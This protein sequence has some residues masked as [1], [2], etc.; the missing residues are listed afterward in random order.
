MKQELIFIKLGGSLIT[1][2][3]KRETPRPRIITSI[4]QEIRSFLDSSKDVAL[5][6]GHGSGSY[7]HWEA[8]NYN[9]LTGI[10]TSHQWRGFARVSAAASR[11]NRLV[12]DTFLKVGVPVLSMQPSASIDS[13]A[14]IILEYNTQ[15]IRN[16][17]THELIPLIFGDVAFDR[18]RGGTIFS[19]EAL[20]AYL[21]PIFQPA[22]IILLGNAPG[23]LNNQGHLIPKITPLNYKEMEQHLHGSKYTDV[24]G[25][26]ADK[27]KLM[28][29]LVKIYP[30]LKV[31]ILSGTQSGILKQTLLERTFNAGT[32]ISNA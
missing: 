26:M 22:H 27:V 9:T 16:C 21:T 30:D 29:D 32:L 6:L 14:G 7:G 20:F 31:H 15:N 13:K 3:R 2:K 17:L 5:L 18:S 10:E 8:T 28:V 19:T 4:A 11:L 12:V 25:G 23:V 1:D 24:T